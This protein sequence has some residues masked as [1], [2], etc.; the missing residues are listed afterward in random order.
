[1]AGTLLVNINGEIMMFKIIDVA[2]ARDVIGGNNYIYQCWDKKGNVYW[3][4]RPNAAGCTNSVTGQTEYD[5]KNPQ[6][7]GGK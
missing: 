7:G 4:N 1:M 6:R 5:K 2:A 3:D